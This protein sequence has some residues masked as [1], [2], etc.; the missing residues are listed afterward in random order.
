ME[1]RNDSKRGSEPADVEAK[2]Q[3]RNQEVLGSNV[4]RQV[5]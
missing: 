5:V 1:M 3:T 2:F 4:G